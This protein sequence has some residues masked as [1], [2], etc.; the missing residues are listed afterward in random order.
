MPPDA[1]VAVMPSR[2]MDTRLAI[3]GAGVLADEAEFLMIFIPLNGGPLGEFIVA[4]ADVVTTIASCEANGEC[5]FGQPHPDL[6]PMLVINQDVLVNA[7]DFAVSWTVVL[8][9]ITTSFSIG[10]DS[11]NLGADAVPNMLSIGLTLD[12]TYDPRPIRAY[13]LFY[14]DGDQSWDREGWGLK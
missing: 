13:F 6:P 14:P 8:D 7:A 10:Y 5:Y 12:T 2:S 4:G 1:S 11:M 9:M 3:G